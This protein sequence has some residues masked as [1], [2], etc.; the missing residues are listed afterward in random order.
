MKLIASKDQSKEA[1]IFLL[2]K[3]FGNLKE[4]RS[5]KDPDSVFYYN[6]DNKEVLMEYNLKN[7]HLWVSY[8]QI[9]S[10]F[11]VLFHYNYGEIQEVIKIWVEETFNLKEVTPEAGASLYLN[12]WKKLSI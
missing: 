11:Q 9:W 8:G 10:F 3:R 4:Y 7:G 2:N 1:A 5:E 12:G 6:P